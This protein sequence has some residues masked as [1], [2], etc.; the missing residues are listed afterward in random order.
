MKESLSWSALPADLRSAL[1]VDDA[2]RSTAARQ[3]SAMLPVL[4]ARDRTWSQRLLAPACHAR[5]R[6]R[7]ARNSPDRRP[8]RYRSGGCPARRLP[9]AGGA[10]P[11]GCPLS[12][13]QRNRS[14][15]GRAR[16]C[17]SRPNQRILELPQHLREHFSHHCHPRAG[18]SNSHRP[19]R[20]T[21]FEEPR[22]MQY[23]D[24]GTR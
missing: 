8:A 17:S 4:A 18:K 22:F 9:P 5:T 23:S 21:L 10:M 2:K 16:S 20:M 15:N 7:A 11:Q 19:P 3:P 6:P 14:P 13:A 24:I 12:P 1:A